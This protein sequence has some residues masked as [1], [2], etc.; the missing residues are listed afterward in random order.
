MRRISFHTTIVVE[1][2]MD[3]DAVTEEFPCNAWDPVETAPYHWLAC[4]HL[5]HG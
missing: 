2:L 3:C 5:E 1:A 4:A